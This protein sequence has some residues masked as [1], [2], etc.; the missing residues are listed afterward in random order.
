MA[1]E[2]LKGRGRGEEHLISLDYITQLHLLHEDWLMDAAR[3]QP[4]ACQ[5]PGLLTLGAAT[6]WFYC[7]SCP[8]R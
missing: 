5:V 1:L 6:A 2:R 4:A 7:N 8:P 3:T